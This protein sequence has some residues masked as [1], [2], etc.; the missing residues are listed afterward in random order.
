[1][2]IVSIV[3]TGLPGFLQPE[4]SGGYSRNNDFIIRGNVYANHPDCKLL[5]FGNFNFVDNGVAIWLS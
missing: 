5:E 2:T 1:M 3:V 4:L